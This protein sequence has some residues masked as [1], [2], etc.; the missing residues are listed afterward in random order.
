MKFATVLL[1]TFAAL[2]VWVASGQEDIAQPADAAS[3][4]QT[5]AARLLQSFDQFSNGV[6]NGT[7]ALPSGLK[8]ANHTTGT[9]LSP[10]IQA[11]IP[12]NVVFPTWQG[13][14]PASSSL[15][16]SI[17]TATDTRQWSDWLTV[18]P[19]DDFTPPGAADVTGDMVTVPAVE[20]RHT[21]LQYRIQ[22]SGA[23]PDA[24]PRL[25]WL[26]FTFIDSTQGPRASDLHPITAPDAPQPAYPKPP[27]VP[28][29]QWC[30][31]P[32]CNY[33]EGLEYVS[34]NHLVVH[35]TVTSGGPDWPTIVRAIWYFHTF[36]RDW[37]DI[38]Y[39]Y[40]IDP[41][42]VIY[43]G[44]L[45]GDDVVGTHAG[46]ANYGTMGVAL[47]GDYTN[48]DPN[49]AMLSALA[50]LLAWKADQKGI[51]VFDASRLPPTPPHALQGSNVLWGLPNLM[52]HRDVFGGTSTQCPG[53][54]MHALLPWLRQQVAS[55]IG[56]VSP[57]TYVEEWADGADT[58]IFTKSNAS[59]H[60]TLDESGGCGSNRH[61]YFTFS[62][63]NPS[64]SVNWA[65]YRPD[66]PYN[67]LYA[68]DV[69]APY[70]DT[71]RA[72]TSGARYEVHHAN[73]VSTVVVSHEAN[74]G[75]WM[76]LGTYEFH[77]DD[78][79]YLRLSDLTTSD[80]GLGVWFDAIRL[81]QLGPAA[82]NVSPAVNAW[83]TQRTVTF[84]WSVLNMPNL[85]T[86]TLQV[87]ADAGFTNLLVN[88]TMGAVSQTSIPFAQ[89][90]ALLYW[91]VIAT[92]TDNSQVI[93]AATPFGIDTGAPSSA[94]YAVFQMESN[95]FMLYWSGTDAISGV[96]RYNVDYRAVGETAWM[97]LLSNTTSTM[98]TFV[99]TDGRDYWFRSQAVDNAGIYEPSHTL[100]DLGTNGSPAL[101]TKQYLPIFPR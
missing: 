70:C 60:N 88:Q 21:L 3:P 28:R 20:G 87:A 18:A 27:V 68:L 71:G 62:T 13:S 10:V 16:L 47:I 42:G 39:N 56:F 85:N 45:G 98:G 89:D 41:N 37:G 73:G 19:N 61:A 9:Y 50:D 67:G 23:S 36:D 6:H 4:D 5:Q 64:E 75:L 66:I 94:V 77:A 38:G 101:F 44:H 22:M 17:R 2:F 82:A 48:V 24:G 11:P 53:E 46:N 34:V 40:L 58:P 7:I 79:G 72:E 29:S 8:L 54:H 30:T 63:T 33:S 65:T 100:G 91:R 49:N 92:A 15:S 51:D 96:S 84:Q 35:H 25:H 99:R 26:R 95:R 55:R 52:G 90:Y 14:E 76:S 80:N 59:W 86:V 31:D 57:Y 74:V 81:R 93:S 1:V 32:A 83:V 69:Y 43:E 97:P 78:S 12:F